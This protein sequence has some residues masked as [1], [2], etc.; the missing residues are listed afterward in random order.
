MIIQMKSHMQERK[1]KILF[2][3]SNYITSIRGLLDLRNI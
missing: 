1:F 2:S 3:D